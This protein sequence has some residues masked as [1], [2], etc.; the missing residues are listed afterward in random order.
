MKIGQRGITLTEILIV[1]AILGIVISIVFGILGSQTRASN[2]GVITSEA[3]TRARVLQNFC[4]ED[5]SYSRLV[6]TDFPANRHHIRFQIPRRTGA[7]D[8][9]YNDAS[10]TYQ[11]GWSAVIEFVGREVYTEAGG[12]NNTGLP[13]KSYV[14]VNNDSDGGDALV[15]G[16]VVKRVYNGT[17]VGSTLQYEIILADD[18]VLNA[19]APV[20]DVDGN[21]A[22]DPFFLLLDGDGNP[23][24]AAPAVVKMVRVNVW[25]GLW[26]MDHKKLHLRNSDKAIKLKNPQE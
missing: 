4:Q 18:V 8:F 5:I 1:V 23:A 21:G 3:D 2:I 9:G 26:D 13:Q 22:V 17:A 24:I 15:V 14:S 25:I 10:N 7:P 20:L 12:V 11:T 6:Y 16:R 19:Q